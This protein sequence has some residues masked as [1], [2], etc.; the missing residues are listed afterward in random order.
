V[1]ESPR[2]RKVKPLVEAVSLR[3]RLPDLGHRPVMGAIRG[4]HSESE[5]RRCRRNEVLAHGYSQES[6]SS[7]F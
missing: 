4:S 1:F 6:R 2:A 7:T 5:S 3:M